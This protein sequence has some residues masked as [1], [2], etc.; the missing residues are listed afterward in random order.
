MRSRQLSKLTVLIGLFMTLSFPVRAEEITSKQDRLSKFSE[1]AKDTESISISENEEEGNS[2][3][4]EAGENT[5]EDR[6]S[7]FSKVA[8]DAEH[9]SVSDNGK[10]DRLSHFSKVAEDAEHISVSDN[11][12]EDRLSHFAGI[13]A[14]TERNIS[15][16]ANKYDDRL[17]RFAAME[18]RLER[19]YGPL[20]EDKVLVR[21]KDYT[22]KDLDIVTRHVADNKNTGTGKIKDEGKDA[23][24]EKGSGIILE[25]SESYMK[26][27]SGAT[28]N[29]S[30]P[31]VLLPD[32]S[33]DRGGSEKKRSLGIFKLTAYDACL[34]CCGKTDG[35]T[36]TGTIAA[37]GRTIAVDPRVI[38]YGSRVMINGNIYIAEDTGK[39]IIG[40]YIDVF[41]NTHER[42][43]QFG[44]K[45]AEVFLLE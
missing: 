29:W 16:S 13:V 32:R 38:P 19:E 8:E 42:A 11:G 1:I 4:S 20:I 9:I 35:I 7:H 45:Q 44:V 18:K 30:M 2:R 25:G 40:N 6:L 28:D 17:S 43:K 26:K 5:E 31:A 24:T 10:E 33:Q 34:L 23:K 36:A 41:L 15:L 12:K 39:K 27:T 21:G 37:E 22:E 14:D 3:T